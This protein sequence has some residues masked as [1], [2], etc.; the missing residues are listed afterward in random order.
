[1]LL[2]ANLLIK[3]GFHCVL[4]KLDHICYEPF[5]FKNCRFERY[6]NVNWMNFVHCLKFTRLRSDLGQQNENIRLTRFE[7]LNKKATECQKIC[8]Y[9]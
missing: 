2:I 3:K 6:L 5:S 1:M 7:K 8:F 4:C 9:K